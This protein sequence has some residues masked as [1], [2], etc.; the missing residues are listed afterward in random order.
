M[1]DSVKKMTFAPDAFSF[2]TTPHEVDN[3]EHYSNKTFWQD[4]RSRMW[5]KPVAM[6]CLFII[7]VII[8]FAIVAPILSPYT[9]KEVHS[10]QTTLKPRIPG[11]EHIGMFSGGT[12][13]VF[14]NGQLEIVDAYSSRGL[15]DV[16]HYFGTDDLG[17]DIWTRTAVG[18]RISLFIAAV[19]VLIDVFIG[20]V[21]GM[22]SGYFGGKVDMIMQRVIEVLSSIP[23]LVVVTLMLVI[24]KPGLVSIIVAMI[25]AGWINMSRV[26]RAQVLKL[27]N[28]E[29]VLASKTLGASAKDIIF[30]DLLPNTMGQ[31]IVTFMFSI[32]NAIFT[33]A[34]LAFIGLGVPNPMASLGTLINDGYQSALTFPYMVILPVIVLA[35]L[36]L[37]FNLFADGLRDAIDPQMKQM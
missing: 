34:F 29:Y 28:Q 6:V 30:K 8:V 35:L 25:I 36:M 26:V 12:E 7:L 20:V 22:I 16:Y 3:V 5:H 31:I 15:D 24:L 18:T 27:K 21:F 19:A 13:A 2:N 11:L 1:P 17:R 33:E 9:Y 10:D 14:R 23:T 32:P 4:V 37:C